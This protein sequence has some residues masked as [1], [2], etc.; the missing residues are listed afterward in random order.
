M[1]D[2]EKKPHIFNRSINRNALEQKKQS[3]QWGMIVICVAFY[4]AIMLIQAL[5]SLPNSMNG[6]LSQLQVIISVYLA[7]SYAWPGYLAGLVLNI[8]NLMAII[9]A[10]FLTHNF[11]PITGFIVSLSTIVS[12]SII[13]ALVNRNARHFAEMVKQ[14]EEMITLNEEISAANHELQIQMGER[15]RVEQ[16][17]RNRAST[18]KLLATIST[19]FGNTAAP[20]IDSEI[21]HTLELLGEYVGVDRCYLNQIAEDGS[22]FST[23]HEWCKQ[24][25]EPHIH[26]LQNIPI[27]SVPW[28]MD[29]LRRF[30]IIQIPDIE[31]MPVEAGIEKEILNEHG[32]RS[33][34]VVPLVSEYQLIGFLGFETT[35]VTKDFIDFEVILLKTIAEI[36]TNALRRTNLQLVLTQHVRQVE[37]SLE[38]KNILLKEI[39]HRVKNN[40]QV[41]SSLLNL[42]S[43]QI[44]DPVTVQLFRDSQNRVRSMALIHEKLYQSH[45]LARID[46]K[47]Y[48]ESLSNYLVRSYATEA[49]RVTF[50]LEIE[51]ISLGIDQ[52]VPCGLIINELVSNSLKYAFPDNQK[53]E[54]TIQFKIDERQQLQLTVGDNGIGFP[55]SIDFQNTAS[56]GLQLVNSLVNQLEG[57][58]ELIRSSGTQFRIVFCEP[59]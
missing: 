57:S 55:E 54:V 43:A 19:N 50:R 53:G 21:M 52:A 18:N 36:I 31:Q 20:E 6:I 9:M 10:V 30:E 2:F 34:V 5:A 41:I 32:I 26:I 51:Q 35:Q 12:I 47:S 49:R 13:S 37:E 56:L 22:T 58:I 40:L 4:I 15:E 45:D 48:I 28:W 44:K 11:G 42:Q 59:V 38:E 33:V 3:V 39:H 1:V 27:T 24:G 29:T 8:L 7:I 17:L 25:I 46:F 14:K 16:T 23:S